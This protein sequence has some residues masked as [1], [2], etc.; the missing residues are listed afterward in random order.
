M[1]Y[2][3]LI[4]SI[5]EHL[6][7]KHKGFILKNAFVVSLIYL[8]DKGWTRYGIQKAPFQIVIRRRPSTL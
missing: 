3:R 4:G 1:K 5:K 8:S 7:I 2:Y 6:Y